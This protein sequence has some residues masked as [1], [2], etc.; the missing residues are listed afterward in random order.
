[1]TGS[2]VAGITT[3]A[4]RA[5]GGYRLTG[6]KVCCTN[7]PE[8]DF[9]V[10]AAKTGP[11][12]RHRGIPALV[13]EKGHP[14]SRLAG[15]SASSVRAASPPARCTSTGPSCRRGTGSGRKARGG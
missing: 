8:A 10:V 12:A 15:P 2:D 11:A 13:V 3:R 1:M 4:V 6:A 5:D 14:G 9:I 7:S